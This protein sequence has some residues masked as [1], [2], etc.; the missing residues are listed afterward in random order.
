ML[1][2]VRF[3]KITDQP[4]SVTLAPYSFLW[5][6]LQAG[7][8]E[9]SSILSQSTDAEQQ[10]AAELIS[11]GW[12]ILNN[13]IHTKLLGDA[14]VAWM[15]RQRWFGSKARLIDELQILSW[16]VM[17]AERELTRP[18]TQMPQV[19][20]RPAYEDL[21]LFAKVIF[22]DGQ[23]DLYQVPLAV[24]IQSDADEVLALPTQSIVMSMSVSSTS[25]LIYDATYKE[26]FRQSVLRTV[27]SSTE[28]KGARKDGG[29]LSVRGSAL[30]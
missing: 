7:P 28:V 21:I 25:I 29:V 13:D 24:V 15:P 8:E 19:S 17:P 6:E 10:L 18:S 2:Y 4:Y 11:I 3:P 22:A 26:S 30:D 20:E 1:G 27:I 23:T 5:L 16:I 12:R 9:A 14:L